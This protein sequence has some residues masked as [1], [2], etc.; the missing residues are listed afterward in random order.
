MHSDT[1]KL[2]GFV[3]SF[4]SEVFERQIN[5][6]IAVT[7]GALTQVRSL[8]GSVGLAVAVIVFNSQI[9][10]SA[11]LADTLSSNQMSALF[12]SP[13]AIATFTPKQQALISKVYATAFTQEMKV[14]TYIAAASF[15]ISLFT[16]QRHPPP[17]TSKREQPPKQ[18]EDEAV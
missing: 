17:A 4:L 6:I 15:V 16:F 2:D 8:G 18:A 1:L 11:S 5:S 10:S 9:R 3:G 13:R 14:A 12:K 7:Q